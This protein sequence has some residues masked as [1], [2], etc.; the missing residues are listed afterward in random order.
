MKNDRKYSSD[1]ANFNVSIFSAF[2]EILTA[3]YRELKGAIQFL[4]TRFRTR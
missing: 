3:F 1:I 2:K 4:S